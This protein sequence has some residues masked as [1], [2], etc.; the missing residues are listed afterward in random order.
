MEPRGKVRV[1]RFRRCLCGLLLLCKS[2]QEWS[3]RECPLLAPD[4]DVNF[5]FIV[6]HRLDKHQKRAQE[7]PTVYFQF[8]Q[9]FLRTKILLKIFPY[10]YSYLCS[11][12][13]FYV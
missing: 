8:K 10:M 1:V 9:I 3:C 4:R 5:K 11:K 6:F 13:G 7:E 2:C 12:K